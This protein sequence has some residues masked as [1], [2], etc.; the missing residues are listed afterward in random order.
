MAGARF[1]KSD[2]QMQTPVDRTNWRGPERLT[3]NST[4]EERRVIAEQYI[5]RCYEVGLEVVAITEHNL[6]PADCDSLIPELQDA[7]RNLCPE[8]G[9]EIALFPGFEVATTV[10]NG[11]HFLCLFERNTSVQVVSEKLT[12]LGLP[13]AERYANGR[14]APTP[15]AHQVTFEML[16]RVVQSDPHVPGL[17]IG[18]HANS[19]NGLMDGNSI[20][21]WWSADVLSDDRL[22]CVELPKAREHYL[23]GAQT[24]LKS[25]L[26]NVDTRYMRKHPIA[27]ICN[28]DCKSLEPIGESPCN[29][30]GYRHTWVKMGEP[31]IEGLRQA[32]LDHGSRIRFGEARPENGYLYPRLERVTIGGAAFLADMSIELAPNLNVLIGGS[33]TGKSTIVN[34]LRMCLGQASGIRGRDVE[35]NFDTSVKTVL[36]E[37]RIEVSAV[38]EGKEVQ[39]VAV[40]SGEGVVG[41]QDSEFSGLPVRT[42]LPVRFFGQREIYNIA[43][44]RSAITTLIDNLEADELARLARRA[45]AIR[46]SYR[47]SAIKAQG[48]AALLDARAEVR[49]GQKRSQAA[50]AHITAGAEPL[51]AFAQAGDLARQL[52]IL[53]QPPASVLEAISAAL[54]DPGQDGGAARLQQEGAGGGEPD[55]DGNDVAE[56]RDARLQRLDGLRRAADAAFAQAVGAALA[57]YE[58]QLAAISRTPEALEI[59]SELETA[60]EQARLVQAD[61]EA[62]GVSVEMFHE[63]RAAAERA[64]GEEAVLNDRIREAES[65]EDARVAALEELREIWSSELALRRASCAKLSQAVPRTVADTPFVEL[66]VK[67]FGDDKALREIL[68][69]YQGDRRKV[70]DAEWEMLVS[71]LGAGVDSSSPLDRLLAWLSSLD[72]NEMPEDFPFGDSPRL[73]ER[74]RTCFP[75]NVRH[76][77]AA[78]RVPDRTVVV[79]RRQDGSTAGEIESGL[80]VGQKCTAILAILLA[81][82]TT[83]VVIDQPEDDI[84]NEFTYREM[85]PLLRR[86]KERRQL[87]IVT[88]DPN[89]P[90]NGDAEMIHAVAAVEGRGVVKQIDGVPAVGSLDQRVVRLAVEEIMEGSE[91]AFR[92][93]FAKY[94]F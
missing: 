75:P 24:V 65:A 86:V 37:T 16:L 51:E 21:Q 54:P 25:V 46:D 5:R 93:R 82:D 35:A 9:Y 92:R 73:A 33:G 40:G 8:F 11:V 90:V 68:A 30:I 34:Y 39:V 48:K 89:I 60:S 7:V 4:P 78:T 71:S 28:S 17:L 62:Q 88:H 79:L 64:T 31:S 42:L 76:D 84:D 52:A 70:G 66:G 49:A 18:A 32:F 57:S 23:A 55:S 44:D 26:Q 19:G 85:V 47:T 6:A 15:V 81:L 53:A 38:L 94:G 83:P 14:P 22:L 61:L 59:A 50:V 58:E 36:P 56:E 27:S 20:V 29:Y 13:V 45:N 91:E 12:Q 74:I 67:P 87:L 43:E 1:Y 10:G 63:Y 2:L 3:P 80:S 69:P 72:N 41:P 77:L